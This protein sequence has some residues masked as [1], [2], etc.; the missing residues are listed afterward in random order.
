MSQ[1]L[2]SI[3]VPVYNGIKYVS[4]TLDTLLNQ[5]LESFEVLLINDGST[6]ASLEFIRQLSKKDIRIRVLDKKNGGIANARNFGIEH[7]KGKFIAFCDQDDFWLPTKLAKQIFLFENKDIGLVYSL[8]FKE[9]TYPVYKKIVVK[10]N[11]NRGD[12]F[13]SLLSENLIPTCSV[14][15]RKN[16]FEKS[17]LFNEK[18]ELMG[19]DDWNVWLRLSLLTKFDFVE[20]P[21]AIHVFHNANYSSNNEVMHK[22]ELVCLTELKSFIL[23]KNIELDIDWRMIE[24]KMNIRYSKDYIN[25]GSFNLAEKALFQ[26]YLLKPNLI[27]II[28]AY[29]LMII[30][31]Q[32]LSFLQK[33][34]RHGFIFKK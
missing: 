29:F 11:N 10:R 28:K 26:A 27:L 4:G 3:I 16:M 1:P 22:A 18:K 25:E 19:V 12:V 24:R 2:V 6:D 7:A 8:I 30:P 21:L 33:I 15:V 17:G 34:K 23:E 13:H 31:N 5:T 9:F 32:I 14:I 20:E